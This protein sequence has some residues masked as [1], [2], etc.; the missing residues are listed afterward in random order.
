MCP[1]S[2]LLVTALFIFDWKYCEWIVNEMWSYF[3]FPKSITPRLE[4]MLIALRLVPLNAMV[5]G[6]DSPIIV[7][8]SWW[9]DHD[10][11]IKFVAVLEFMIQELLYFL[12]TQEFYASFW[13]NLFW[14]KQFKETI[15]N[16]CGTNISILYFCRVDLLFG[17]NYLYVR[18]NMSI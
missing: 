1:L 8:K 2:Q 18:N 7:Y 16:T 10:F 3:K 11:A 6:L 4:A 13:H 9:H 15:E 12:M 14:K 5:E 17:Y